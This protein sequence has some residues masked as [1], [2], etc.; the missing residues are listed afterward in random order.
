MGNKKTTI[1]DEKMAMNIVRLRHIP[2]IYEYFLFQKIQL[3][4]DIHIHATINVR[5]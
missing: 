3:M 4:L 2:K 5:Y 1:R